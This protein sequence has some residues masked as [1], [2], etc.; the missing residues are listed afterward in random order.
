MPDLQPWL[1]VAAALVGG[2]AAGALINAYFSHRR[3]RI[4]SI[5]YTEV[6]VNVFDGVLP[7]SSIKA[8][9]ILTSSNDQKAE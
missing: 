8:S 2:G 3:N 4:Q 9:I 5:R 6:V 7:S 1:P